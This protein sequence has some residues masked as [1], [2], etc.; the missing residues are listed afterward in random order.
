LDQFTQSQIAAR[1]LEIYVRLG[2]DPL[3]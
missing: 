1:T 3:Q 2:R